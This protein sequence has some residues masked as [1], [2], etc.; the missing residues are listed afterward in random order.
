MRK[1]II[2]LG[3]S[4]ISTKED[5]PS[6][7]QQ[8]ADWFLKLAERYVIV[9]IVG[10][11]WRARKA[12]EDA[13]MNNSAINNE[14][15]DRIGIE[16]TRINAEIMQQLCHV[17]TDLIIDPNV[18][19]PNEPSLVFGA[20]WMPG[21][22]TDYDAVLLAVRNQVDTIYNVSNITQIYTADPKTNPTAKPLDDITWKQLREIV[23]DTW[24][25]GLNMPFDPIAAQLAEQHGLT[26]K[27]MNGRDIDNVQAAID[28]KPFIGT[29]IHS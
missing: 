19:L 1:I 24:I 8:Y 9:V 28:G 3:G 14:Q 20:G 2:S 12:I 7:R 10:G 29:V 17:T 26:V 23:G 16:A 25:P 5:N 4:I 11:G 27:V 22:S 13:K 6:S 21:R 15:L 18:Q